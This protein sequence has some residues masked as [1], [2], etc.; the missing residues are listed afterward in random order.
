[1]NNFSYDKKNQQKP[2]AKNN[3]RN[4]KKIKNETGNENKPWNNRNENAYK[5]NQCLNVCQ[6]GAHRILIE[7]IVNGIMEVDTENE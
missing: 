4:E 5:Y 6:C 1:M 7:T 2:Q 3:I